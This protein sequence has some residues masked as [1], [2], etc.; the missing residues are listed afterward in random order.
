MSKSVNFAAEEEE[1]HN[2]EWIEGLAILLAV[3]SHH[4]VFLLSTWEQHFLFIIRVFLTCYK[5]FHTYWEQIKVF[6]MSLCSIYQ[7]SEKSVSCIHLTC[8]FPISAV[9]KKMKERS[10]PVQ[11]I[12]VLVTAFNDWSKEKQ[13]RGLQVSFNFTPYPTFSGLTV[14]DIY[15]HFPH[16]VTAVIFIEKKFSST[17]LFVNALS[18]FCIIGRTEFIIHCAM[19]KSRSER[20]CNG[21]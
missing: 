15:V 14:I 16:P 20:K 3:V 13:F 21:D 5:V 19:E 18:M 4:F 12:V 11:V 1:Q 10:P 7:L 9:V 8:I 17:E 2:T 6:S